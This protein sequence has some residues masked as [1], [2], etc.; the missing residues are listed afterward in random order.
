[1]YRSV[2]MGAVYDPLVQQLSDDVTRLDKKLWVMT[3]AGVAQ[4]GKNRCVD[5]RSV[6][7]RG[8]TGS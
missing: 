5:Q 6:V 8:K 2:I 4:E 3:R 1:M 7:D